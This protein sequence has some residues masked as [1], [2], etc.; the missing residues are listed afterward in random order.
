MVDGWTD[1]P[2]K[3]GLRSRNA[4]LP[5]KMG[6]MR[7]AESPSFA[8][9]TWKWRRHFCLCTHPYLSNMG[10]FQLMDWTPENMKGN[11]LK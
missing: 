11:T 5:Y 10:T 6:H 2:E 9:K 3:Q 4:M 1:L 7:I 8:I